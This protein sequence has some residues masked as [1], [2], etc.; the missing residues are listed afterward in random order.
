MVGCGNAAGRLR[1]PNCVALEFEKVDEFLEQAERYPTLASC[2]H[3]SEALC[4]SCDSAQSRPAR[5]ASQIFA[6]R[7]SG[8]ESFR[9]HKCVAIICSLVMR[10]AI[11]VTGSR[12][13]ER[14][15]VDCQI[16]SDAFIGAHHYAFACA[17]DVRNIKWPVVPSFGLFG[18]DRSRV[19]K[20]SKSARVS[21]F[22]N[23]HAR[24]WPMLTITCTASK[25]AHITHVAGTGTGTRAPK[26]FGRCAM[27][28][29]GAASQRG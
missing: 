22:L 1:A 23:E 20:I 2:C 19:S 13:R 18:P 9:C 16:L 7:M 4:D 17:G 29:L 28:R 21:V 3:T 12:H 11:C 6:R 25:V 27:L 26:M 5:A 14:G 10:R 24:L 8:T 15:S